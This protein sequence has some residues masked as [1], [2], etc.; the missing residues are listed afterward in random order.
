VLR[1]LHTADWHLGRRFPQF[2]EEAQKKLSRARLDVVSRILNLARRQSV[3]A[4]LCAGDV[5][6]DPSPVQ[7]FWEALLKLLRDQTPP[8]APLF[9]VP[10]NHDPLTA[11]SVWAPHHPFR[12]NLPAWVHVVDR[13]DFAYELTPDTMLYAR[14]CRSKAGQNDLA[15]ALPARE[16]GDTRIR[17]GCVHG[18]TFDIDGYQINFP[19]CRDAGV[20][21]GLNYLAIGDAHSFRDVTAGSPVPTVYPGT[22]EPTTFDEP[23]AGSV[24]LVALFRQGL[25]PRVSAEPVAFW[26]WMDVR[27]R[28]LNE[29][30]ALLTRPELERH[31]IRLH[32]DMAVSVS[33][34]NEVDRIVRELQG[35]D[36]AHARAGIILVDR[37]GLRLLPGSLDDFPE[38]LPPVVKATIDRLD[39]IVS[40]SNDEGEK[41]I[42]TRALSHL[43]KLL[44]TTDDEVGLS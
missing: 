36:A 12:S 1:L 9:F 39:R 24:A 29:L 22:P 5:F 32:L 19:I 10:G 16:P 14:P 35:T 18:C 41:E 30:R 4:I 42:A 13:D 26:R 7:D 38:N 43:Y 33:E 44:Q 31:V 28:D 15:M 37:S 27:C 23:N 17:I 40:N 3:H 2:P 11:E 6:D 21:R 8:P 34:E 20:L 25:R